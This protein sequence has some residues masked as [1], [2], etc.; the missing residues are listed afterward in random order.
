MHVKTP[1]STL[2][3]LVEEF[4]VQSPVAVPNR[5][6]AAPALEQQCNMVRYDTYDTQVNNS[7]QLNMATHSLQDGSP[8]LYERRMEHPSKLPK[9][10]NK[11][12]LR[13]LHPPKTSTFPYTWNMRQ[14]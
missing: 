5:E 9:S 7:V 13:H 10:I 2:C 8:A 6:R 14:S 12:Y 3:G 4:L 1:R 11:R